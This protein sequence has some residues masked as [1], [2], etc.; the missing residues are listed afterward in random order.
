MLL[1]WHLT[2]VV[3]E[4]SEFISLPEVKIMCIRLNFCCSLCL[5]FRI[6]IPRGCI[7]FQ[8]FCFFKIPR[9]TAVNKH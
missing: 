6:V 8:I 1:F 9:L 3:S 5:M 2:I 7:N 4:G